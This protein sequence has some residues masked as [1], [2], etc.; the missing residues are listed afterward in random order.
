M[1]MYLPIAIAALAVLVIVGLILSNKPA[2]PAQNS[3]TE[4][5]SNMQSGQVRTT[6]ILS[7]SQIQANPSQ[8][9]MAQGQAIALAV[10]EPANGAT[11]KTAQITLKGKTAP[12]ADVFVNDTQ[13]AADAQ[14]QFS[15]PITLEEGENHMLITANDDKGDSNETELVVTYT[16]GQ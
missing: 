1:K 12:R 7:G 15:T 11:V 13:V 8:S 10:T 5:T 14:G 6:P 9:S 16:S 3:G 4:P 2:K